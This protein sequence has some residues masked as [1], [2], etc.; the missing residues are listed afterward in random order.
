MKKTLFFAALLAFAVQSQA[1]T[2]VA[3]ATAS[4]NTGTK[5]LGLN[6]V[7]GGFANNFGIGVKYQQFVTNNVRLEGSFDYYFP[8]SKTYLWDLN[9]N[10]HYVFRLNQKWAIYPLVGFSFANWGYETRSLGKDN[11]VYVDTDHT[12]TFGANIGAGV[13]YFLSNNVFVSGELKE[14]ILSSN[15]NQVNISVG[16]GAQ[17]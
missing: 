2:V 14:Q 7:Y 1:Q 5:A 9:A 8:K 3:P 17:F 16:I 13:Q 6:F 4:D 10:A 15:Y 12:L 11:L